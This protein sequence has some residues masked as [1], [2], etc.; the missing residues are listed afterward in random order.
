[1]CRKRSGQPRIGRSYRATAAHDHHIDVRQHPL[2]I[3]T[4]ALANQS[5]ESVS[6]DG[7]W[8]A[9]L[10]DCQPKTTATLAISARKHSKV[11]IGG[12]VRLAEDQ[13]EI[14][15]RLQAGIE[16]QTISR[17]FRLGRRISQGVIRDRPFALRALITLRP[18]RDDIRERNPCVRA[19]FRRLGWKV[20][21]ISIAPQ[22]TIQTRRKITPG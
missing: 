5:L 20:R 17:E 1:M 2:P 7:A 9:F 10:C 21:F 12:F 8:R 6:V 16:G 18:L 4:E 15:W 19:R 22:T 3:N 11:G 14:F 13:A